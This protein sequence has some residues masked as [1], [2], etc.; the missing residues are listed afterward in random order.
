MKRCRIEDLHGDSTVKEVTY[1]N[2]EACC[3]Y[4][5][6]ETDNEYWIK[7]K[8]DSFYSERYIEEASVHIKIYDLKDYR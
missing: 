4:I 6:G 1:T 8:T 5:D 2:G 7:I 3:L